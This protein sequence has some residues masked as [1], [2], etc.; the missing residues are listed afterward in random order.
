MGFW[1][2]RAE[3]K[4]ALKTMKKTVVHHGYGTL[5]GDH[6]P[7]TYNSR[8]LTL[9]Y[10]SLVPQAGRPGLQKSEETIT[11]EILTFLPHLKRLKRLVIDPGHMQDDALREVIGA[12]PGSV[13]KIEFKKS[14]YK[15]CIP[16]LTETALDSL[17]VRGTR[18]NPVTIIA[19]SPLH[20]KGQN[21]IG[22]TLKYA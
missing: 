10:S 2:D 12:L 11:Q 18:D 16:Q 19:P 13:E 8:T 7:Y 22:A 14:Q 6:I 21:L 5:S 17:F 20:F 3:H 1:A 15:E 9:N 4:Q